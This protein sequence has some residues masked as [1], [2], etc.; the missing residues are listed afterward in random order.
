MRILA[1]IDGEPITELNDLSVTY[2]AKSADDTDGSGPSHGD[3]DYQNATSLK[4]NGQS[5]NA[6]IDKYIVVPP[7]IIHGVKGIVLGCQARAKNLVN[8]MTTDAVVG[9]IGPHKKLGEG[10]N[11]FNAALGINPSPTQG[12]TPSHIVFYTLYPG[13]PAIVDGKQYTLQPA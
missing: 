13:Q 11:A 5:L 9:D 2:R 4:Q 3:P 8:G 1:T 6:D 12:G 7:A 10:S